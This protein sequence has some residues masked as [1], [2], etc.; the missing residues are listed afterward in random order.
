MG[1]CCRSSRKLAQRWFSPTSNKEIEQ[2]NSQGIQPLWQSLPRLQFCPDRHSLKQ[3]WAQGLWGHAWKWGLSCTALGGNSCTAWNECPWNV[4]GTTAAP[5]IK[6]NFRQHCL[7]W[8]WKNSYTGRATGPRDPTLRGYQQVALGH[9]LSFNE[10][11]S[12]GGGTPSLCRVGSESLHLTKTLEAAPGCQREV[13]TKRC[14]PEGADPP[15]T[16]SRWC[17]GKGAISQALFRDA[18]LFLSWG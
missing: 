2:P 11:S 15:A 16:V 7:S 8:C 3:A 18:P 14:I 13:S 17:C 5:L 4:E 10:Y 9:W 1:I 12:P 6:A